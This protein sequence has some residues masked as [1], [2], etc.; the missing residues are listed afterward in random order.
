[1]GDFAD[2]LHDRPAAFS[3]GRLLLPP[4]GVWWLRPSDAAPGVPVTTRV[5]LEVPTEWGEEVYLCGSL[6]ALGGGAPDRA[7][8]PLSA[9]DYPVWRTEIDVPAGT[10]FEFR[11]LKKRDGRVVEWGPRF[12]QR[13]GTAT[14]WR[15]EQTE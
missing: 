14:P 4:Y 2:A 8:G 10:H 11:W 3:S 12:A 7:L 15:I 13:A 5:A 1:M 9:A 6:D